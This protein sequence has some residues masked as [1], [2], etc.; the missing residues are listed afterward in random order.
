MVPLAGAITGFGP[1]LVLA[2]A[3]VLGLPPLVAAPLA[4]ASLVVLTGA[5]HEDG[6]ADC[7]DGFGGGRT[8]ERKLEIMRDSR[9]GTFGACAVGLSLYLR[10]ACLTVIA[11]RDMPLAAG[12]LVAGAA[13]SRTLCLLPLVILPPAREA[14]AGAAAARLSRTRY[15][16]ALGIALVIS[17]L[18]LFAGAS[19]W[20]FVSA[21][22]VATIAALLVTLLARHEIGGQT[23][24]VAGA[25]QQAAELAVLLVFAA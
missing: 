13:L 23:G 10:I 14:G 11:A 2:G 6:L 25:A 16:A 24:D 9:I 15:A 17:I 21:C 22:A 1:L 3:S 5:L 4:V 19:P 12:V 20:H 7:A 8:R 18:P